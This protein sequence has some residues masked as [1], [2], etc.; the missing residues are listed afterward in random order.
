MT[1]PNTGNTHPPIAHF[2]DDRDLELAQRLTLLE[3]CW[4]AK[5]GRG[6]LEAQ[7]PL[8]GRQV[9]MVMS[10]PSLRTRV[11]LMVAVRKLGGEVIEVGPNNTK[12]GRGEAMQEWAAV[13]GSMVDIIAARVHAHSDLI[14][15]SL[16]SGIPV[17]N[18]LSDALHPCQALADAYTLWEHARKTN[19]AEAGTAK[20][21]YEQERYWAWV[22]DG[23][24]VARSLC[25]SAAILGVELRLCHPPGYEIKEP[26]L[27]QVRSLHRRGAQHVVVESDPGV[28]VQGAEAVF[29]DTWVSMGE[30][31]RKLAQGEAA[32]EE[33]FSRY[34]VDEAMMAKARPDAVF[35]HCLPAQPGK[36]VSEKVLRGEQSLVLAG[37]ENR[38]WSALALLGTIAIR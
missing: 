1:P 6:Q 2:L 11:S 24:N 18:A 25:L 37:A 26:F 35:M 28:A 13:L 38:L 29:T 5:F 22:G 4:D 7:A 3:L 10:K 20:G 27:Q 21:Y 34:R 9:A 31:Q 17:I 30:E 32:L 14:D 36:E 19:K 12:L 33:Q 16:Y 15:L 23:N 8:S